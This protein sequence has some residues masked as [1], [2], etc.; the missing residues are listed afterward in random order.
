[1]FPTLKNIA[2]TDNMFTCLRD[3]RRGLDWQLH[4][5]TTSFHPS[6][7]GS[8][9]LLLDLSRFFLILYTVGTTPWTGDQPVARPLP[10]H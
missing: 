3:Y 8:T 5:L 9:L 2:D 7:Y 6:I 10:T 4:L 1:M